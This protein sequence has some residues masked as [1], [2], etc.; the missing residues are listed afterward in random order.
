MGEKSPVD[1]S[2]LLSS[3]PAQPT[4]FIDWQ[5]NNMDEASR[6]LT[7]SSME[8]IELIMGFSNSLSNEA[9]A[10]RRFNFTND[11]EDAIIYN[12]Y[13][14]DSED[15]AVK[16]KQICQTEQSKKMLQTMSTSK[17]EYEAI[18]EKSMQARRENKM[19]LVGKYMLDAGQPYKI[20]NNTTED[21]LRVIKEVMM[22]EEQQ[23]QE[24]ARRVDII[25]LIA[26]IINTIIGISI[27]V[28]VS[29]AIS[30]PVKEVAAAASRIADGD[31]TQQNLV[32]S[33][34]D[35]I[36]D[37][38]Q[39]FNNMK[40]NLQQLVSRVA[41]SAEQVAA[42][43]EELTASAEQS[44]QV[45]NQIAISITGVASVAGEQHAA[46]DETLGV[47]EQMSAGIKQVAVSTNHVAEQSAMATEKAKDGDKVVEKAVVQMNAIAETTQA[48]AKNIATL[49]EKSQD[50][51][52]IV[53]VISGIASQT[54]L[55]ALNAAIEAARAGEHGRGFAVVADEVRKLAEESQG[56]A[57]RIA[58]LII[59]IQGDTGKAV[60]A[61]NDSA[62]EVK[63][64]TEVVTAAGITF[65]EIVELV[66]LVSNQV[67]E[68]SAAI[69]QISS[70]SQ[71]VVASIGKI[72]IL[73]QKSAGDAQ[74]VS[75]ATEEQSASMQ[76]IA[77]SSNALSNLAQDLQAVVA[78]FRI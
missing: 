36:G 56:A 54:N 76:E 42:S 59:E 50:I 30:R 24:R 18:V 22:T 13:K 69:Q 35:E 14:K 52:Q 41:Q 66:S 44:A 61:M 21:L 5:N 78:K 73:S 64:G 39:A 49:N 1:S 62:N 31:L 33:T 53:S 16:L 12:E 10:M 63:T 70:G 74:N 15:K 17:A 38:A 27:G 71:Q 57:K 47:V 20:A 2:L 6:E 29:R 51:G 46:T 45:S 7:N 48:F 25:I 32:I 43:S 65:R 4:A 9:V 68:I 60:V 26:L 75:A 58:A 40:G 23:L 19:D 28:F 11:E 72:D 67:I 34:K 37:L 8:R 55:L 3:L 77:S